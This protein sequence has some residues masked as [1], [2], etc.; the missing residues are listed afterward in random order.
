MDL[1]SLY[2]SVIRALN[3]GPETIIGQLRLDRTHDMIRK[4][5]NNK[6][7]FAE[8]WE[9]VFNTLEYDLVQERDV[10]EKITVDW[11]SGETDQ[12]TGAEIY[13][14]V[15]LQNNPWAISANGT[16]FKYDAKGVVPNLLERWYA[17]RKEMQKIKQYQKIFF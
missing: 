14:A 16:I 12:Y 8:A 1:N 17:E 15:F 6:A 3:M 2:P 11:E 10:A 5:M 4:K 13:D 7:T 9:G